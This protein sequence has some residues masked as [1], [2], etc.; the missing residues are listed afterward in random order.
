MDWPNEAFLNLQDCI[1]Q[2]WRYTHDRT[3]HVSET[4]LTLQMSPFSAKSSLNLNSLSH[5]A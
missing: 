4:G 3:K 2:E 1:E 5:K